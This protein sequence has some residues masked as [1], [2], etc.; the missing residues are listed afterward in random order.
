[1]STQGHPREVLLNASGLCL[2]RA[3]ISA[4]QLDRIFEHQLAVTAKS[5]ES[6][7]QV[8]LH[9]AKGHVPWSQNIVL[10]SLSSF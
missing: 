7:S 6:V 1:M 9:F 10:H 5:F 2:Y 8:Y 3:V 4:P